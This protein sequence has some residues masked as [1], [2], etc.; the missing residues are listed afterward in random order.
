MTSSTILIK[1]LAKKADFRA[2]ITPR[3][4]WKG[5]LKKNIYYSIGNHL[6]FPKITRNFKFLAFL[7]YENQDL[8]AG[9]KTYLKNIKDKIGYF[10]M[11]EA[12]TDMEIASPIICCSKV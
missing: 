9:L 10:V 3:R 11:S 1:F 12:T 8:A 7:H 6:S 4:K 5:K 2:Q